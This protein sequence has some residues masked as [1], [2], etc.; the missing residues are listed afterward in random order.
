METMFLHFLC[1]FKLCTFII[2]GFR[3]TQF[4]T[5]FYPFLQFDVH[6]PGGA[7][8]FLGVFG[9]FQNAHFRGRWISCDLGTYSVLRK[10]AYYPLVLRSFARGHH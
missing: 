5:S 10:F 1:G 9:L 8:R 6:S 2:G 3:L 7:T 4:H